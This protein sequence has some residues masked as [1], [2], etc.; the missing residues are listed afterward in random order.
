LISILLAKEGSTTL[1]AF[2]KHQHT[3]TT[4][5]LSVLRFETC[6][7]LIQETTMT[8]K[9]TTAN[10]NHKTILIIED[11]PHVADMLHDYFNRHKYYTVRCMGAKLIDGVVHLLEVDGTYMPLESHRY[12]VAV[13]DT[14]IRDSNL[15][16]EELGSILHKLD[17]AVAYIAGKGDLLT[18]AM[19]AA[20]ADA[21]IKSISF[22]DGLIHGQ[23]DLRKFHS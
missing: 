13:I 20:C 7:K 1:G 18:P 10:V 5:L 17:I 3:L 23:I 6:N 21:G 2:Q 9:K 8:A 22:L 16:P 4:M 15:E 12:A 19:E 11:E 14:R